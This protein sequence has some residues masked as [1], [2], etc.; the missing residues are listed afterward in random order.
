MSCK[1]QLVIRARGWNRQKDKVWAPSRLSILY[2]TNN[3]TTNTR[4]SD[5]LL[6]SRLLDSFHFRL[7][8]FR[9]LALVVMHFCFL[10]RQTV[11]GLAF[12]IRVVTMRQFW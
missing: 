1:L 2:T 9:L 12:S 10:R 3:S 4:L 11:F 5:F 7:K 6:Y 8:N